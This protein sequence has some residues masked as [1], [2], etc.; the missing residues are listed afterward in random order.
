MYLFILPNTFYVLML[1]LVLHKHVLSY[2]CNALL[3]MFVCNLQMFVLHYTEISKTVSMHK[4][5]TDV[6][7]ST[8]YLLTDTRKVGIC[9][10]EHII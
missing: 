9:G 6:V 4:C 3:C 10:W 5:K 7:L 8:L 1:V 2:L